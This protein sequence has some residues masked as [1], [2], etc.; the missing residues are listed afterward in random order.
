MEYGFKPY[1]GKEPYIFISYARKD[2]EKVLPLLKSLSDAGYNVWYDA[3]IEIGE[4]WEKTLEMK[5]KNCGLFVPLLSSS[6]LNS[7]PCFDETNYA[8]WCHKK[9]APIY[10]EELGETE[11]VNI[12]AVL[13]PLQ[14]L[15]FY[16]FNGISAFLERLEQEEKFALC[17]SQSSEEIDFQSLYEQ[18][19]ME[20]IRLQVELNKMNAIKTQSYA[21]NKVESPG[22]KINLIRGVIGRGMHSI[23]YIGELNGSRLLVSIA[24]DMRDARKSYPALDKRI[25]NLTRLNHPYIPKLIEY[26]PDMQNDASFFIMEYIRGESLQ[27]VIT[28]GMVPSTQGQI[29][30]WTC[31]ILDVLAYL[32]EIG[33]VHS[34]LSAN[35]IILTPVMWKGAVKREI[36]L[37]DFN[38]GINEYKTSQDMDFSVEDI[39]YE[40]ANADNF[41]TA[42]QFDIH[43]VGN[44]MFQMLTGTTPQKDISQ[45]DINKVLTTHGVMP[46]V[47]KIICKALGCNATEGYQSAGEMLSAIRSLAVNDPRRK[48]AAWIFI[49]L[50]VVCLVS[51]CVGLALNT[52][53][54]KYVLAI[55]SVSTIFLGIRWMHFRADTNQRLLRDYGEEIFFTE[56]QISKHSEIRAYN[57]E[58]HVTSE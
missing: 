35:N 43:C 11:R 1:E 34:N 52:P 37:I 24:H 21:S 49:G 5:I 14:Y 29:L 2:R 58:N 28:H 36:R 25:R 41:Q 57:H 8:D 44:V 18:V 31:Q 32:H 40:P 7:K 42:K 38:L 53:F 3:G 30:D 10:L 15:P 46:Q 56:Q 47:R 4:E 12:P 27:K 48:V 9:M 33:M 54:S 50:T 19:K 45:D 26:I 39:F 16:Q 13:R 23:V 51:F 55:T 6:S 17:K 20:N 22:L